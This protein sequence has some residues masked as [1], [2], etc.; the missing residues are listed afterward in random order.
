MAT[1]GRRASAS[2]AAT[3]TTEGAAWGAV[4]PWAELPAEIVLRIAASTSDNVTLRNFLLVSARCAAQVRAPRTQTHTVHAGRGWGGCGVKTHPRFNAIV[5]TNDRFWHRRVVEVPPYVPEP[6]V[7]LPA[8]TGT[9]E[10]LAP[11]AIP[12][13]AV[14][15]ALIA[16]PAKR[17]TGHAMPPGRSRARPPRASPSRPLC[18]ARLCQLAS[19]VPGPALHRPGA[20]P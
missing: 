11:I 4:K 2:V 3:T 6:D 5:S 20:R 8:P 15:T 10:E 19:A 18:A 16:N 1:R 12:T 7:R 14:D 9:P 17:C 13:I